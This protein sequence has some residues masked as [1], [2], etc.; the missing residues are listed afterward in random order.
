MFPTWSLKQADGSTLSLQSFPDGNICAGS[1]RKFEGEYIG[2][3]F[4]LS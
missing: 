3:G 4:T 2:Q 1:V